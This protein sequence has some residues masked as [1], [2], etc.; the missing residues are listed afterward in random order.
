MNIVLSL[1]TAVAITKTPLLGNEVDHHGSLSSM[2]EASMGC[3]VFGH[4]QECSLLA[5]RLKY[6]EDGICFSYCMRV[7]VKSTDN[8]CHQKLS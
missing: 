4:I 1:R 2:L 8:T 5:D 7:D 6:G 3:D